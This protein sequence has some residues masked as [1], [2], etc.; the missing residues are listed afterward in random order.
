M[1]AENDGKNQ[2]PRKI[3]LKDKLRADPG[4]PVTVV[5]T[6][7]SFTLSNSFVYGITG[8][9]RAGLLAGLIIIP[10]CLITNVLDTERDYQIWKETEHMRARGLPSILFP[11]KAKY[12]WSHY[13]P[14]RKEIEQFYN[15]DTENKQEAS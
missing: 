4:F 10:F 1:S 5:S 3:G 6:M 8:N 12:D 9:P 2:S 13:E 11:K 7:I 15:R 14:L